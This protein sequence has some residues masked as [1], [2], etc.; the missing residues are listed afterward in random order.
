M[1]HDFPEKQ[2]EYDIN[3]IYYKELAHMMIKAELSPS[4]PSANWSGRKAGH[5]NA[6]LGTEGLR[7]RG[8]EG[9]PS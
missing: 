7:T 4:L 3:E 9:R 2:N 6:T 1:T 5:V 8:A